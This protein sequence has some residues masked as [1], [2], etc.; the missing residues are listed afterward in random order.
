MPKT[1][2]RIEFLYLLTK[3][4]AKQIKI[5]I[6]PGETK[7]FY[8]KDIA[9]KLNLSYKKLLFWY[10]KLAKF[11]DGEI[12]AETYF[13][14]M[15]VNEKKLIEILLKKSRKKL[16]K[17]VKKDL[18]KF[19]IIA[20]IIQK[21][22]ANKN[23]MPLIASVIYNRLK[24]KMKLQ[25]DGSLNY[26]KFSH[27]VITKKIIRED[28][29]SYNTYKYFGLPKEPI[30]AVEIAAIKAALNP[31]KSNFLY[32]VKRGDKHI[33]SKSYKEHLKNIHR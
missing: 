19:L 10:K 24:R 16:K 18:K 23:E 12:L 13:I 28:N 14:P 30:C 29:S 8:L 7:E 31:K 3:A 4:K 15:G 22:A 26:K 1:L 9:K 20:S 11:E 17:L 5:T 32:F 33:F 27:R 25:M 2:S 6:I 21:E